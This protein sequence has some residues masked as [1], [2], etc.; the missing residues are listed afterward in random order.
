V[1]QTVQLARV[2]LA[3]R[4]CATQRQTRCAAYM[5][6]DDDRRVSTAACDYG[7]IRSDAVMPGPDAPR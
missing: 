2:K 5:P 6:D 3:D 7:R 4:E 1:L